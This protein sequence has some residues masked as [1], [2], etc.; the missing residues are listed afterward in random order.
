MVSI[1]GYAY[2]TRATAL[3]SINKAPARQGDAETLLEPAKRKSQDGSRRRDSLAA[4]R[5]N[6]TKTVTL[7]PHQP[8]LIGPEH[9]WPQSAIALDS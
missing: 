1:A 4:G 8:S 6:R 7:Y 9:R 5:F 2:R 3:Y